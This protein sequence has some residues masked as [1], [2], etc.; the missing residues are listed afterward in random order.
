VGAKYVSLETIEGCR[1]ELRALRKRRR[2]TIRT[3]K[4]A[5]FLKHYTEI[6]EMKRKGVGWT[7]IGQRYFGRSGKVPDTRSLQRYF[8][9]AQRDKK[10]GV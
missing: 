3:E 5:V 10:R 8:L 6:A 9:A 4:Y 2:P 1:V 7:E